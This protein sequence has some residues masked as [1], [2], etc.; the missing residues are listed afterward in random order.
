MIEWILKGEKENEHELI[1]VRTSQSEEY[2]PTQVRV[3]S[4]TTSRHK[5]WVYQMSLLQKVHLENP[6]LPVVYIINDTEEYNELCA[7]ARQCGYFIPDEGT[8]FRKLEYIGEHPNG[9]I[10]ISKERFI[11]DIGSY[12]TDRPFCYVWDNMDIDRYKIMWDTLPFEGDYDDSKEDESDEKHKLTSARQC[13]IAAWPIFEH[14]H[15]MVMANSEKTKFYIFDPYFDDYTG[16]SRRIFPK[17]QNC[18]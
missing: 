12:R 2:N 13:I 9:M 8:G 10:I 11:N 7:Y 4:S 14:Y 6:N 15:S 16:L 3:N 1:Q 18:E 5:Y 17:F